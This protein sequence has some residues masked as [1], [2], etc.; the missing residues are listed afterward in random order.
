MHYLCNRKQCATFMELKIKLKIGEF[1]KL[2]QVT[3]KTL[4]FYERIG[5]L[6][7]HEV[8]EWTGYRYYD[9]C[10][11]A[12]MS[13]I[14][15]LKS[16]GFSLEEIKQMLE[17]G[18]TT[19][20]VSMIEEKLKACKDEIKL[21]QNRRTELI[22]LKREPKEENKM[23]NIAIKSLPRIIVASYRCVIK[24]YSDLFNL[25]PNIIG[26][27]MQRLGCECTEPGYCYTINHDRDYKETDIDIEYCEQ[28]TALK[29]D[30]DKIKFKV[31]PEVDKALC[32]KHY[33]GYDTFRQSWAKAM[34]FME[35]NGYKISDNPRFNYIDG[36]WNKSSV[37][38]WLTEIQI[39]IT[40]AHKK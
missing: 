20:P 26:P 25:C 13:D 8:D 12:A 28:V 34:T 32:Y 23:E 33:G 38:D 24:N 37:S 3:V 35:E 2:C 17:D 30:S 19:P 14:L 6:S 39:P 36:I 22:A 29:Q 27:E 21:L 1:S 10:Q 40:S 9:V 18:I 16:L 7:P 11:L 31:V 4:R 15:H 5:L